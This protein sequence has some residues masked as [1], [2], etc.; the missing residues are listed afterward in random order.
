MKLII[1]VLFTVFIAKNVLAQENTQILTICDSDV[2]K[3]VD[4]EADFKGGVNEWRNYL[5]HNLDAS[6]PIENNAPHG[7]YEV[8]VKFIV[9]KDG[10]I[11]NVTP[12]TH[13]G[14]GMENEAVRIIKR[15]PKWIPASQ[16]GQYVKS[17]KIQPV[18]FVLQWI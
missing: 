18:T 6:I 3:K 5:T 14:Y 7:T 16:N 8:L 10:S 9:N 15:G 13:F 12:L 17:Y 11:T 2:C 1:C 4:K